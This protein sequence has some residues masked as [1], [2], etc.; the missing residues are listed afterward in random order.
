MKKNK[1]KKSIFSRLVKSYV[2]FLALSIFLYFAVAVIF[3][4]KMGNGDVGNISP[5]SIVQ[6][7]GSLKDLNVLEKNG[8]W[9]E[10]LDN[11]GKIINV[12]GNK[13]TDKKGYTISELA[14]LLDLGYIDYDN[15]GVIIKNP[16]EQ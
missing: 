7:D 3:L 15:Y 14:Y 6:K 12:Y 13:Q 2:I 4:I 9:V 1:R 16:K 5:Q 10:E 8:G 11:D